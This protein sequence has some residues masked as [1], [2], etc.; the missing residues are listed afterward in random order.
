MEVNSGEPFVVS[1][2]STGTN[3]V[4]KIESEINLVTKTKNKHQTEVE[5]N[6]ITKIQKRTSPWDRNK[7]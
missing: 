7:N 3:L 6:S 5:T 4:T 2:I 1:K